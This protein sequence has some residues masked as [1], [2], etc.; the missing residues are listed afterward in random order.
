[1]VVHATG[2]LTGLAPGSLL[3]AGSCGAR[4]RRLEAGPRILQSAIRGNCMAMRH[5]RARARAVPPQVALAWY[6]AAQWAKLKQVAKDC[7]NIED[8]Y[9][10]WRRSAEIFERELRR[11]GVEIKRV[12]VDV[13]SLVAWCATRKR[14]VNGEARSEY[15][16]Q[17]ARRE[18]QS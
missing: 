15:A 1:M 2:S 5:G 3:S 6:D 9:E 13:E 7:D 17:L 10:D 11:K 12:H 4:V 8:S 16:A 18:A 14:P